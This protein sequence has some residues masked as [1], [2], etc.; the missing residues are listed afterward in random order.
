MD[1]LIL[2]KPG[3]ETAVKGARNAEPQTNWCVYASLM[4]RKYSRTA[5]LVP[6]THIL[7]NNYQQGG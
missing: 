7:T 4:G 1:L 6:R 3:R 2:R 5:S